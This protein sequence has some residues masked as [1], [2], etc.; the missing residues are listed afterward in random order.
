LAGVRGRTLVLAARDVAMDTEPGPLSPAN[1]V[2][3]ALREGLVRR[4]FHAI[5]A[6]DWPEVERRL[7]ERPGAVRDG[8][9]FRVVFGGFAFV[10][11]RVDRLPAPR[12]PVL[13]HLDAGRFE[14]AE[15]SALLARVAGGA[16][17]SDLVVWHGT[18]A[19]DGLEA[20]RAR[21]E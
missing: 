4:V 15:A 5:P 10:V 2:H 18:T 17:Q 9:A 7:A 19:P 1:F 12:E 21:A 11:A 16:P 8:D 6:A 20:L 13:L 3:L 14:P